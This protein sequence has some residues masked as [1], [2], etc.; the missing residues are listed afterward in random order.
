[1]RRKGRRFTLTGHK[2]IMQKMILAKVDKK[3]PGFKADASPFGVLSDC[4]VFLY[5]QQCDIDEQL[6]IPYAGRHDSIWPNLPR[7]TAC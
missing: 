3:L 6:S 1:M 5:H 2:K 7:T 4:V